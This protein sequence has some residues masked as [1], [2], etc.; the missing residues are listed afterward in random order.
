MIFDQAFL[1]TRVAR[2]ILLLFLICC[3][4]PITTI[5]VLGYFQVSRE[6]HNQSAERLQTNVKIAAMAVLER[7]Q[8]LD[9]N[10]KMLASSSPSQDP[11]PIS[12]DTTSQFPTG[13]PT[14]YRSISLVREGQPPVP[15]IREREVPSFPELLQEAADALARGLTV[16]A[17]TSGEFNAASQVFLVTPLDPDNPAEATIWGEVNQAYLWGVGEQASTL[18]EAMQICIL[19]VVKRPLF[20]PGVNESAAQVLIAAGLGDLPP[21]N[22]TW[23][24]EARREYKGAHWTIFLRPTLF[25]PSWTIILSQPDADIV[26]GVLKFR[27]TFPLVVLLSLWVALFLSN[28]QVRRSLQPLVELR[29]GTRRIADRD[30]DSRVNITSGDEFEELATSFNGMAMRLGRQ[31]GALTAINEIDRAILSAFKTDAI[32]DTVFARVGDVVPSDG[33]NVTLLDLENPWSAISHIAARRSGN[34]KVVKEI[35]LPELEIRELRENPE[36]LRLEDGGARRTYLD[37]PAF[38]P[39]QL[40]SFLVLPIV[41]NEELSGVISLGFRNDPQ[42][43]EDDDAHA[44]QLA[45]QMGV[46][47]S[48]AQLIDELDRL[49]WGVLVALARAID[50]KS[51][52]TAGHSERVTALACEIGR[53]LEI[54]DAQI[55]TLTRGGLLHDIGKIGTPVAVLDKPGRLSDEELKTMRDHVGVGAQILE[56]V[57]PLRDALPIL[58]QHHERYDGKGYPLG[59]AGD[60]IDLLA[61]ILSVADAFD[62]M[63]S[64]R[65]YRT[66]KEWGEAVEEI[67][68]ESGKAFNPDAVNAFL[69]LI[70]QEDIQAIFRTAGHAAEHL[71][72][73]VQRAEGG[74]RMPSST[75]E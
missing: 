24:D 69:G 17:T 29:L 59:L 61:Q 8:F 63:Q 31:F 15:L 53:K 48:N 43:T 45:D 34:D 66:G 23:H 26:A 28:V 46:A 10:L 74:F 9:A 52:W 72:A 47:L 18:P 7:L 56:P 36:L 58:L 5:G 1:R 13:L 71:A 16:G 35:E 39:G 65:P 54:S 57:K 64:N 60:E 21:G 6:L 41:V 27:R 68:G 37:F 33:L 20:C 32:I 14:Y 12:Q 25:I 62:A 44:R 42:F 51:P 40:T 22:F 3:L 67:R 55:D 4:L 19:D 75:S 11:V 38:E 49:N 2:R 50:A 30:F 70:G 73:G